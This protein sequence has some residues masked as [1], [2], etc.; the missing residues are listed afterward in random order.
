ELDDNGSLLSMLAKI[1]V[2]TERDRALAL[3]SKCGFDVNQIRNALT[4]PRYNDRNLGRR[5]SE[6]KAIIDAYIENHRFCFLNP[7]RS[8][9][10]LKTRLAA[11]PDIFPASQIR[12]ARIIDFGSGKFDM[13]GMSILL[14]ANMAEHIY[15]VEPARPDKKLP[16]LAALETAKLILSKPEK[17]KLVPIDSEEM[18]RRV[19]T[20]DYEKIEIMCET[21]RSQIRLQCL[22]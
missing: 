4:N 10:H 22:K 8:M 11:A 17:Y 18:K 1:I 2:P 21:F 13:L 7:N 6:V 3:M 12:D 20:I 9:E 19:S 5:M 15:A 14:F 16:Y